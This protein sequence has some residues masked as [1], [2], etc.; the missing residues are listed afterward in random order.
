MAR[1]QTSPQRGARRRHAAV[2]PQPPKPIAIWFNRLLVSVCGVI[3]WRARCAL[4][5]TSWI[6]R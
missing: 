4:S 5:I 1:K 6:L 3:W 2:D